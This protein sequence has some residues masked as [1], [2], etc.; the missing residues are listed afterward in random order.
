MSPGN[1]GIPQR[2]AMRNTTPT[3]T[4]P[5]PR[6]ISP[7]P[8]PLKSPIRYKL[9]LR[10]FVC[11]AARSRPSLGLAF[12]GFVC[13]SNALLVPGVG[14]E[15]R[16][17]AAGVHHETVD[18]ETLVRPAGHHVPRSLVHPHPDHVGP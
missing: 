1:R 8:S 4:I 17:P 16:Y 9:A 11:P 13:I 10:G 14:G 6:T 15:R 7:L 18:G 2:D 12:D 3:A 5:S